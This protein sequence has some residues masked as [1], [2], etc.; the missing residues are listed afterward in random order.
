MKRYDAKDSCSPEPVEDE[1]GEYVKYEDAK[2]LEAENKRYRKAL[3]QLR[4]AKSGKVRSHVE[5]VLQEKSDG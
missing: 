5:K 1:Q 4:L 2:Q 3:E